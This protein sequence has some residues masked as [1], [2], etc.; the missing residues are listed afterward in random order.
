MRGSEGGGRKGRQRTGDLFH[1][2]TVQVEATRC[3]PETFISD[4]SFARNFCI[5]L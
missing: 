1:I 3:V 2:T 5:N 4:G